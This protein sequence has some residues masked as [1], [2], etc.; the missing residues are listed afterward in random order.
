MQELVSQLVQQLGID[1]TKA[2]TGAAVLFKAAQDK[3]GNAEFQR[4]LGS[5]PGLNELLRQAPANGGGLLGGLAS[6]LG[7]NAALLANVVS[8]FGRLGLS[9]DM[10][11]RFVPIML[12]FLRKH[13][14]ADVVA[15]IEGAL[16]A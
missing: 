6:A 5:L 14:G 2:R 8:G 4:V 12:D 13:V 7:G 3:L 11:K 1:E 15:E 9:P 10:A 16:R